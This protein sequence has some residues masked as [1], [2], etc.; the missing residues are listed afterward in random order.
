[1]LAHTDHPGFHI[2]KSIGKKKYSAA[3][4]GGA[5]FKT[6]KGAPVRIYN[7]DNIEESVQGKIAKFPMPTTHR[8]GIPFEIDFKNEVKLSNRH[9]GAFDFPGCEFKGDRITTRAA[10]DLAGVVIALGALIDQ[11]LTRPLSFAVFTRAEEVGFIGCLKLLKDSV[12]TKDMWTVSLEASRALPMAEI[13]KGPVLR[14]GD[15]S[16]V[17]DSDFSVLFWKVAMKLQEKNKAFKYQRR[18]MD[19]G[20]CEATALC[21][22][23]IPT[24]GLAVPLLNYHNQGEK[25][26][27]PEKIS[28]RDVEYGRLVCGALLENFETMKPNRMDMKENL[29]K[30]FSQLEGLL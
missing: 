8:E 6:M 13:T 3:W 29:L 12:I 7:P 27:A 17:F 21:L 28:L 4:F 9:F 2:V 25:K 1:M 19:G 22:Y 10:D 14:L 15:R 11:P 5:P 30:N 26:P 18:L 23:D 20:S 16:S 24:T